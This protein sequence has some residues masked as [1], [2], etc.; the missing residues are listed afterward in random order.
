M[1]S[2]PVVLAMLAVMYS[3]LM[4]LVANSTRDSGLANNQERVSEVVLGLVSKR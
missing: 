2:V 4:L 3:L 1:K